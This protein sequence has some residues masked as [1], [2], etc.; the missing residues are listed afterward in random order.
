[1]KLL[2]IGMSSDAPILLVPP[3]RS[4][5]SSGLEDM[6][7]SAEREQQDVNNSTTTTPDTTLNAEDT[8]RNSY[9]ITR[10][11]LPHRTDS[12]EST[13]RSVNLSRNSFDQHGSE[14]SH[15]RLID[16]RRGEAPAYETIDLDITEDSAPTHR[17]QDSQSRRISGFLSRFIS[18]RGNNGS[19]NEPVTLLP[20]PDTRNSTFS[21]SH[22]REPSGQSG[23][24]GIASADSHGSPR[25]SRVGPTHRDRNNNSSTGSMFTVLSRTLSRNQ[26]EAQLT[27]PSMI[28]LNSISPPLTHTATRTEFTYPRT[29]PTSEQVKFLSSK[30]TFGRFGLP[31]G[32]DAV[33]FAASSSRQDL[34]PDFDSIH[35]PSFGDLSPNPDDGSASSLRGSTGVRRLSAGDDSDRGESPFPESTEPSPNL[36]SLTDPPSQLSLSKQKSSPNL[37]ADILTSPS[38]DSLSKQKST[39]NLGVGHP[40]LSKSALKSKSM[41]NLQSDGDGSLPPRSVSAA[42]S[43]LTVESF[44]TANDDEDDS[45]PLS[46]TGTLAPVPQITV[47]LPSNNPSL[48]NL[49]EGGSGSETEEFFDGDEDT[50]GSESGGGEGEDVGGWG[51]KTPRAV[52]VNEER[53]SHAGGVQGE[54]RDD[55][56]SL[57]D[58]DDNRFSSSESNPKGSRDARTRPS[59]SSSSDS[60]SGSD[61]ES[62]AETHSNHTVDKTLVTT[63][64]ETSQIR[65]IHERTDVTLTPELVAD[66]LKTSSPDLTKKN[67]VSR[68]TAIGA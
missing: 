9:D 8:D 68:T 42:D 39:P 50:E 31:Y 6:D 46:P 40:P 58:E 60:E 38:R 24:S 48:T 61:D 32:P 33:A 67:G 5:M 45:I 47:Q 56:P 7:E 18:H 59:T 55:P 2:S 37:G 53:Q 30:E 23:V 15:A 13:R 62:E 49:V 64:L 28:S 25:R 26:D 43:Y 19:T 16:V 12:P 35:R 51:N 22:S 44:Q 3:I 29:G 10:T 52:S 11:L 17:R 54:A 14:E 65:H 34:P 36:A 57:S 1:M 41:A 20:L 4:S 21:P 63:D 27:S 66:T